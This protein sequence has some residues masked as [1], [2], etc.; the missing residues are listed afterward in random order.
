M[1]TSTNGI[2]HQSYLYSDENLEKI[3]RIKH[4]KAKSYLASLT[5]FNKN[6]G[7]IKTIEY[8]RQ[9]H[10]NQSYLFKTFVMDDIRYKADINGLYPIFITSTL[11]SE[12]H[13]YN[14]DNQGIKHPNK[15]Y[16]GYSVKEGADRLTAFSRALINDFKLDRK[17]VKTLYV[18]VV[19]PHKSMVAHNH[20][21]V[22]V[23]AEH[24]E[25]FRHHYNNTIARFNFNWKGQDYKELN[26]KETKGTTVYLLKYVNK[27]LK[28]ENDVIEGWLTANGIKRV[29]TNSRASLSREIFKRISGDIPFNPK[30]KRPYLLQIKEHLIIDSTIVN[31]K[32]LLGIEHSNTLKIGATPLY[33]VE[34][35][36]EKNEKIVDVIE[37]LTD[38]D[39]DYYIYEDT[40]TLKKLVITKITDGSIVYD[41]S[42]LVKYE[43][44][45]SELLLDEMLHHDGSVE[46]ISDGSIEDVYYYPSL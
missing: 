14:T 6:S 27:T 2:I 31:P 1:K 8:D 28:G 15:R 11:P 22:W 35:V 43:D 19:E 38:E 3:T 25:A 40:Y 46:V 42:N 34:M 37:G 20:M 5:L 26:S 30:D 13:P 7:E 44:I 23:E 17:R 24:L 21:I 33:Y 45:E 18:R 32:H 16:N 41:K 36:Q 4:L 29:M 10:S 39:L 12:Y 9:W